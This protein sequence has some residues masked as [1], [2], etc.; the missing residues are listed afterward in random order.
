[1]G[2]YGGAW[3]DQAKEFEAFP[4]PILMTT[5]CIQK[6]RPTYQERIFTCGQVGWPDVTH[7]S[8]R[9]F[10]PVID[11]ALS[12]PGFAEDG[13]TTPFSPALATTPFSAS[14]RRSLMP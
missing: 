13:R 7:I 3:Q 6:P 14:R 11:A 5:N 9:N 12:A 8:D 4:G 2:N 1:V 10:A